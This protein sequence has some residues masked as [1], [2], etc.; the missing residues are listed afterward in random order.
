MLEVLEAKLGEVTH[1]RP[2]WYGFVTR[3]LFILSDFFVI[4]SLGCG[5]SL[6][7]CLLFVVGRVTGTDLRFVEGSRQ[8]LRRTSEGQLLTSLK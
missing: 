4:L 5:M 8:F 7:L 1:C 6:G 3:F 2:S